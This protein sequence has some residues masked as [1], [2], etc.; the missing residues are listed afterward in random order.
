M[1]KLAGIAAD[2]L[3]ASVV[4]SML[5]A[6]SR[7]LDSLSHP[8]GTTPTGGL[9]L[10]PNFQ[11][12]GLNRTWTWSLRWTTKLDLKKMLKTHFLTLLF[13]R[14]IISLKLIPYHRSNYTALHF[15]FCRNSGLQ[16][17]DVVKST[18]CVLF[19]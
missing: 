17:R 3:M 12:G 16:T 2:A 18:L 8:P 9:N 1:S 10:L 15:N 13:C 6:Q 11:K 4:V 19:A 14:T 7:G 5:A